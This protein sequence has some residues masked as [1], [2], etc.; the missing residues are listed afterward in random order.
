MRTTWT[1]LF[2]RYALARAP[3]GI[4]SA[5]VIAEKL[6][7]RERTH[8][9]VIGSGLAIPHATVPGLPEPVT[10]VALAPDPVPFGPPGTD[11]VRLFGSSFCFH[12]V[13]ENA[14]T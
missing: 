2:R 10:G 14:S 13:A 4:G 9:T 8:S 1:G 6:L 7:E 5:D 12:H 3:L 11:P